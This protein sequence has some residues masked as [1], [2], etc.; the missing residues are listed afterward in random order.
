VATVPDTTGAAVFVGDPDG[1]GGG[2]ACVVVVCVVVVGV[3]VVCV[4]VVGVVVVCVVVAGVV[5][6]CVV[7]VGVVVVVVSVVVV[8]VVVVCVVVVEVWVVLVCAPLPEAPDPAVPPA[9]AESGHEVHFNPGCQDAGRLVRFDCCELSL[10]QPPLP[11]RKFSEPPR[12][13]MLIQ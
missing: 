8:G 12:P 4:V 13:R 10:L 9:N 3:V 5:V 11:S 1:G 7:V 6:V 2:G